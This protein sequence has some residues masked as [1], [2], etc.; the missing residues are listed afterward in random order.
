M[1]TKFSMISDLFEELDRASSTSIHIFLIGGGALMK[2][3]LKPYTKDIDIVVDSMGEFEE[4]SRVLVNAGFE[5]QIPGKEYERLAVSQIF[6]RGDFR[7]DLFFKYVCGK[8]YLSKG[9]KERSQPEMKLERLTLNVCS[10]EDILLFKS[11]TERDGDLEDSWNITARR[12]LKWT[13]ILDE[14]RLQSS[15]ENSVWI[16]WITDRLELLAERGAEIPILDEMRALSDK[17]INEWERGLLERN[18]D[19]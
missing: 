15:G 2:H 16:T 12:R 6:I 13:A 10:L 8:F 5:T 3:D 1:I 4:L 14:A 17:Y 18:K 11:M 19:M 7:I 9:M